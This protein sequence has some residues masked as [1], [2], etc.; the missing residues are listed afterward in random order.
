VGRFD[1]GL[2]D[3]D[4]DTV[5][6]STSMMGDLPGCPEGF[7]QVSNEAKLVA[8]YQLSFD[9]IKGQENVKAKLD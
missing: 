7:M 4:L 5:E 8:R 1:E 9:S 3:N 6:S 2:V